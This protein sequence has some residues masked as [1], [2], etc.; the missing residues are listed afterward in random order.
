MSAGP[1]VEVLRLAADEVAHG[2]LLVELEAQVAG[3]VP[4]DLVLLAAGREVAPLVH[5]AAGDV[6]RATF[7]VPR[8]ALAEGLALR[9]DDLLVRLPEPDGDRVD[10]LAA[11][12]RE[13]NA[14]RRRVFDAEEAADLL[15]DELDTARAT[16][17]AAQ[18]DAAEAT[19]A[20]ADTAAER[21]LLRHR[22][23]DLDDERRLLRRQLQ[24]ARVDVTR[25][26]DDLTAA[27][28]AAATAA[29]PDALA[30]AEARAVEAEALREALAAAEARA[31]DAEARAQEA[32]ALRGAPAA[33]TARG[34]RPDGAT[35]GSRAAGLQGDA[36]DGERTGRFVRAGDDGSA[37]DE[38]RVGADATLVGAGTT[39]PVRG[40]S[41]TGTALAARPATARR[42]AD[43]PERTATRREVGLADWDAPA[44]VKRA[45]RPQAAAVTAREVEMPPMAIFVALGLLGIVGFLLVVS[46]VL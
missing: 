21:D 1:T 35:G 36:G 19:A 8:A 26:T 13:A 25:L 24:R 37:A 9:T 10:R 22:A 29:D 39:V 12:A 6:L 16:V 38:A 11:L 4:D 44:A 34:V 41:A 7:A 27:H 28:E 2:V 3:G 23:T 40:P 18:A 33:A 31:L 45:A 14:L 15:R 46:T 17:R 5:E 42:T 20:L 43:R 32:A 30:A